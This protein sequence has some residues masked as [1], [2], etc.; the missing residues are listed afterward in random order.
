MSK[1][2]SITI[3]VCV[4]FVGIGIFG[5][6]KQ[7]AYTASVETANEGKSHVTNE[8]L[9]M[10]DKLPIENDEI[11]YLEEWVPEPFVGE[12]RLKAI[13]KLDTKKSANERYYGVMSVP[14]FWLLDASRWLN[15]ESVSLSMV[16]IDPS[17]GEL[18]V[19]DY[20]NLTDDLYHRRLGP[21]N[22][23]FIFSD[24]IAQGA[25]LFPCWRYPDSAFKWEMKEISI[26]GQI[27]SK[28]HIINGLLLY[29][30]VD[31]DET[32]Y[33]SRINYNTGEVIWKRS[34]KNMKLVD[35]A[36]SDD[37]ACLLFN[38]HRIASI[39]IQTGDAEYLQLD[40]TNAVAVE[41]SNERMFLLNE[42]GI[43]S[44]INLV[45]YKVVNETQLPVS[46]IE[47]PI[48]NR[49]YSDIYLG[50]NDTSIDKISN[51]LLLVTTSGDCKRFIF[52]ITTQ[53]VK[54]LPYKLAFHI[55]GNLIVYKENTETEEYDVAIVQSLNPETLEPIW[56]IDLEKEDLG[57]NPRVIWCDWR[58]VLV[59][60]DT[61][62]ACF[63]E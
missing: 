46:H 3:A 42:D 60:S 43:L 41:T 57:D 28:M 54:E 25:F 52:N 6:C 13:W 12:G 61:K 11:G 7:G 55:N 33:T 35:Y 63:T 1:K 27:Y 29:V 39:N 5:S 59:M 34:F 8:Q 21:T 49:D 2:L 15:N 48:L 14:N 22:G 47:Q 19:S 23:R 31:S 38:N 16:L 44:S 62:L 40:I 26:Y 45:S 9:D 58:G 18:L 36:I 17:S 51:N 50:F 20:N 37:F 24:R 4:I 56:W 32:A 30:S 53:E 10:L